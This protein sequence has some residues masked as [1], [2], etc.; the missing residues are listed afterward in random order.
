[1]TENITVDHMCKSARAMGMSKAKWLRIEDHI[2]RIYNCSGPEFLI[3]Y[4]KDLR[5]A[6]TL[7]MLGETDLG[8]T[9]HKV[10]AEGQPCGWQAELWNF[11]R[12]KTSIQIISAMINSIQLTHVSDKQYQKWYAGVRE[13]EHVN[14]D[15]VL[16][17]SPRLRGERADLLLAKEIAGQKAFAPSDITGTSIP[18]FDGSINILSKR[19]KGKKPTKEVNRILQAYAMSINSAPAFAAQ[20]EIDNIAWVKSHFPDLEIVDENLRLEMAHS[21]RDRNQFLTIDFYQPSPEGLF[22]LSMWQTQRAGQIAFLQQ[23]GGKLR[24]IANPNRYVQ[25]L[26]RPMQK[27]LS[28]LNSEE[29]T[30]AVQDQQ[31][32][33]DWAMNKLRDGETLYSFDLSAATDTLDFEAFIQNLNYSEGSLWE[34]QFEQFSFAAKSLWY[35]PDL[36]SDVT[37]KVG[38]PLGLAP[39]FALLTAMNTSAGNWAC[40]NEGVKPADH[41][42]CVGDD[43]VCT[44]VIAS[45]Y[46]D[47]ITSMGGKINMEKTM[48][49]DCY[50]EFCSQVITKNSSWPLKP[51][52]RGLQES[53]FTDLEKGPISNMNKM[54]YPKKFKDMAEYLSE[55]SSSDIGNLPSIA[56]SPNARPFVQREGV[57]TYLKLV[58]LIEER[59]PESREIAIAPALSASIFEAKHDSSIA[60]NVRNKMDHSLIEEIESLPS[61][62]MDIVET[63]VKYD[64]KKDSY[65]EPVSSLTGAQRMMKKFK[66]I[67]QC[68]DLSD[69]ESL[70]LG[71]LT[72]KYQEDIEYNL[73][74]LPKSKYYL[75]YADN[76]KTKKS[77]LIQSR[78]AVE[79]MGLDLSGYHSPYQDTYCINALQHY[80]RMV[81]DEEFED[82]PQNLVTFVDRYSV[83]A[84]MF[85]DRDVSPGKYG[86]VLKDV[87]SQRA[88]DAFDQDH[89]QAQSFKVPQYSKNYSHFVNQLATKRSPRKKSQKSV[90]RSRDNSAPDL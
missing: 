60:E 24:T 34:Q 59:L 54:R 14:P 39:S 9:W 80:H 10:N 26:F 87:V 76:K 82:T 3:S 50:A 49:S 63:N 78:E 77:T 40:I 7:Q 43:F 41:F 18:G 42:R 25:H 70:V 13:S 62:R 51:K 30:V 2:T 71:G 53:Y 6:K 17:I 55:F 36:E 83:Y 90:S 45:S 1:M 31:A 61:V 73:L 58:S 38:Q 72:D 81:L 89:M 33:I 32:G 23:E 66:K 12:P 20:M 64:W 85:K 46:Y 21:I 15:E 28:R 19:R 29:P 56:G 65:V 4:L 74:L 86:H 8:L 35:S 44:E 22:D 16:M 68:S 57:S 75:L 37:W 69:P 47:A 48:S 27:R 5:E 88:C 79:S 67:E 11:N 84:E 52:I